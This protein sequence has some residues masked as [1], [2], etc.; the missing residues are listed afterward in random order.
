M[1]A[2]ETIRRTGQIILVCGERD[3]TLRLVF[4][5]RYANKEAGWQDSPGYQS[6]FQHDTEISLVLK[7]LVIKVATKNVMIDGP[8]IPAKMFSLSVPVACVRTYIL[9]TPV[10]VDH[11]IHRSGTV[12]RVA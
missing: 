11:N 9:P 1:P 4:Q 8:V 3:E 7:T 10:T 12:N 5:I 2:S 6:Q